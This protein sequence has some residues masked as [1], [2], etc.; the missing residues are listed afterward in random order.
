VQAAQ[1]EKDLQTWENEGGRVVPSDAVRPP[2]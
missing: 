2:S 1:H